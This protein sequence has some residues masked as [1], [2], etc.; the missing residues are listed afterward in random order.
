MTRPLLCL[1]ALVSLYAH[2]VDG[3][4]TIAFPF[5]AQLPPVARIGSLW[6][7][8]LSPHTF[9]SDFNITYTLGQHPSW[10]SFEGQSQ[11]L[12]GIAED[13][14][15]PP[16]EVVG[17]P[18]QII[19][20]DDTGS[21][22]M[23]A[24]IVVSRDEGPSIRIPI[25]EQ[26]QQFGDY[27][28]PS[29]LLTY[30]STDF[31]YTFDQQTFKHEPNMINYYATSGNSSP[32]PAWIAFDAPSLT[33]T[34]QTPGVDALYQPPQQFDIR[35]V[36]SDIEGFSSTSIEFSIVVSSHKITV[37]EPVLELNA[38]RGNSFE[39]DG[40]GG[41]VKLDGKPVAP[42]DL[43]V[44]VTNLPQWLSFDQK[45]WVL[46]GKP[47]KEDHSTN[48][49]LTFSDS[50]SDTLDVWGTINVASG[51]FETTFHNI[52]ATPGEEFKLDLSTYLK[53]PKDTEIEIS[54][55]PQQAWLKLDGQEIKGKVPKSESGKLEIMVQAQSKKS[56]IMET[57]TF[58]LTF[59]AP[60]GRSTTTPTTGTA[61]PSQT[62][63]NVD[64]DGDDH[65]E[66]GN[67]DEEGKGQK[68]NAADEGG[69]GTGK[70]LL[71]TIIP[72]LAIAL[73]LMLLICCLKRQRAR[74]TYLSKTFRSKISQPVVGSLRVNGSNLHTD[75]MDQPVGVATQMSRGLKGGYG[76]P[77]SHRSSHSSAT[78][79]S[80]SSGD[81]S[82]V[83][84]LN[85]GPGRSLGSS[86]TEDGR[87]SW[88]TVGRTV[89]ENN[90]R[91]SL[92]TIPYSAHQLLPTPPLLAQTS[93]GF[94]SGLDLTIPSLD[95]LPSLQ[96]MYAPPPRSTAMYST[97]TTSS[98]ALPHSRPTSPKTGPATA[99]S[100]GQKSS[101]SDKDWSTIREDDS[102]PSLPPPPARLSGIRGLGSERESMVSEA[103]FGSGENWRVLGRNNG[104]SV[105]NLSTYREYVEGSPFY[106]SGVR[107]E[108]ASSRLVQTAPRAQSSLRKVSTDESPASNVQVSG[109]RISRLTEE[110]K[111]VSSNRTR[112]GS[113]TTAG[114]YKAF[115]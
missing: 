19:A 53:D 60:D 29:S 112:E 41:S 77:D 15:V 47:G 83:Y 31:K 8:T 56:G 34:G 107:D 114:S 39:Y 113:G 3:T 25:S 94:R 24:E 5:N 111:G 98:A 99:A 35:L 64:D 16:G 55:R 87:G 17:Q 11:R 93:E 51:L 71:A 102:V 66:K 7:Y 1:S 63:T 89:N 27:S 18:F 74:R 62:G 81:M 42:G 12:Y 103:S 67:G 100:I 13:D 70:I 2:V 44:A 4:P 78:L 91:G 110:S 88:S 109:S 23:D 37:D 48:F 6:T 61:Q 69:L 30:P 79:G 32:L 72:I 90:S 20:T 49:T 86:G 40:L 95:D 10:M 9:R 38:S 58:A 59:L 76:Q 96:Q 68:D 85:A 57:E 65:D 45:S 26:I 50:F 105:P 84:M 101:S 43:D 75:K 80:L 106:P 82:Q 36:A 73:L 21:A 54:T 97:I 92:V 33:F 46:E 14:S 108:I 115:I 22:T 52:E 104:G 28:A